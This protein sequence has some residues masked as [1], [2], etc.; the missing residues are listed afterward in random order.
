VLLFGHIQADRNFH[1]IRTGNE[2]G[3]VPG[4]VTMWKNLT[5][6]GFAGALLAMGITPSSAQEDFIPYQAVQLPDGGTLEA[7]DISFVNPA[8]RT[9]SLSAS[10]VVDS[11]GPFGT[12]LIVDT[13]LN[14]VTKELI[15]DPP[16]AGA[17]SFPARMGRSL[18]S[19]GLTPKSGREMARF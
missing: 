1:N 13:D 6:T 3:Y 15:P 8:L 10:R 11:R 9:Y 19:R 5:A 2:F 18:S 12:V 17:C 7:F 14:I 16:F 4:E